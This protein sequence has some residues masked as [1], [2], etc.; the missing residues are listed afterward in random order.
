MHLYVE[1]LEVLIGKK[2]GEAEKKWNYHFKIYGHDYTPLEDG[3][4]PS[5]LCLQFLDTLLLMAKFALFQDLF[6]MALADGRCP[7]TYIH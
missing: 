7:V 1:N 6:L 5:N 4:P 2:V 3:R